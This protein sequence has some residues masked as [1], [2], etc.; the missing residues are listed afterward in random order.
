MQR[1]YVKISGK[2]KK[3]ILTDN[4]L[5]ALYMQKRSK[6]VRKILVVWAWASCDSF[7]CR[8][9]HFRRAVWRPIA[10]VSKHRLRSPS[11]SKPPPQ[12]VNGSFVLFATGGVG[13]VDERQV[14]VSLPHY[15]GTSCEEIDKDISVLSLHALL[16]LLFRQFNCIVRRDWI[17][18]KNGCCI[19]LLCFLWV[20]LNSLSQYSQLS[21]DNITLLQ[22]IGYSRPDLVSLMWD[23]LGPY[24]RR[25]GQS[26]RILL[27]II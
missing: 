2:V 11:S 14:F 20:L 26:I 25:C 10:A 12:Q 22:N 9:M 17:C 7:L 8:S 6:I 15:H 13:T 18:L 23:P 5:H 3:L 4:A 27:G 19:Y 1:K 21:E 24:K 16:P